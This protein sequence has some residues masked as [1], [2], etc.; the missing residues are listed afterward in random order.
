[1]AALVNAQRKDEQNKLEKGKSEGCGLQNERS[2]IGE[3][4]G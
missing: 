2:N 4:S 1:M 3:S